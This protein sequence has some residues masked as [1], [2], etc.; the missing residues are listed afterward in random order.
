MSGDSAI[1]QLVAAGFID[2]PASPALPAFVPNRLGF[3]TVVRTSG[4]DANGDYTCTLSNQIDVTDALYLASSLGASIA[5]IS[6]ISGSD[7]TVRVRVRDAQGV[8]V[9]GGVQIA[10]FRKAIG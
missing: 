6:S 7:S 10:I 4:G 3:T 9:P 8:G 2:G 5:S 1:G